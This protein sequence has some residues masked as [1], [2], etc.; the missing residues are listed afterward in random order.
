MG[1]EYL[2]GSQ[3]RSRHVVIGSNY[4]LGVL[5]V[6]ISALMFSA[7]GVFVK[8]LEAG[9][10]DII[11]WRGLFSVFLIFGYIGFGKAIDGEIRNM[12]APGYI[13]GAVGASSTLAYIPA[14]KLTSI[15]NVSLIYASMPLLSAIIAICWVGEKSGRLIMFGSVLAFAG[16]FIIVG[17]S[18]EASLGET[19]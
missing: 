3:R 6:L 5:Y 12:K 2:A 4:Y 1:F 17:G 13:A 15:A 18:R 8:W 7:A 16:V 14:F 19:C 9:A 11:F 10:W